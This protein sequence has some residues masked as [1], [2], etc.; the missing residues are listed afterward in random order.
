MSDLP[1]EI[2]AKLFKI[3]TWRYYTLL[4]CFVVNCR[5]FEGNLQMIINKVGLNEKRMRTVQENWN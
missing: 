4:F 5:S 1:S 3:T 2:I